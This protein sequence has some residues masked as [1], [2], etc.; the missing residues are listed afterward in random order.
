MFDPVTDSWIPMAEM[1]MERSDFGLSYLDD[2]LFVVGGIGNSRALRSSEKY[3]IQTNEWCKSPAMSYARFGFGF[4]NV[5]EWY[6]D[7][8]FKFLSIY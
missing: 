4:T 8:L 2:N 1:T 7:P 3:Y 6:I 5:K